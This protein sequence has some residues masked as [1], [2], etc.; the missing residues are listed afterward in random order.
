VDLS[1]LQVRFTLG[2]RTASGVT[3]SSGVATANFSLALAPGDYTLQA[4][5][6]GSEGLNGA[7]T[8]LPVTIVPRATELVL[9]PIPPSTPSGV[10][11]GIAATLSDDLGRGLGDRAVRFE[12]RQGSSVQ[13]TASVESDS[14]GVARLGIITLAPGSYTLSASFD[15]DASYQPAATPGAT[16]TIFGA[17][18]VTTSAVAYADKTTTTAT[19]RGTVNPS[20]G[21]S[22]AFF[23]IR[24]ANGSYGVLPNVAVSGTQSGS[25]PV[26]VSGSASGLRPG[27][28]Y[29]FRLVAQNAAGITRGPEL[30]FRTR[31]QLSGFFLPVRNPPTLNVVKAGN[32]VPLRFSLNGYYGMEII[33]GNAPQL[34]VIPCPSQTGTP[35]DE[36]VAGSGPLLIYN[37]FTD[38]YI[39]VWKTSS[40]WKN[41]CRELTLRLNDG[42]EL[43][44]IF[45]FR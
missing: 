42:S 4:V 20:G 39:Y 15:G 45:R 44:A 43:K 22:T 17:P 13:F 16:V 24:R 37:G 10:E 14:S 32:V 2:S 27:T 1:G 6:L 3:N 11:A 18:V 40:A 26:A 29:A 33:E 9:G 23:E 34:R 8:E 30:Q 25:T 36:T 31:Y 35:A 38:R 41:S 5:F 7:Q 21:T 28:L 19:L 12:L